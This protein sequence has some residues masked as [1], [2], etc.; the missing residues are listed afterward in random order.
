MR[1]CS[2]RVNSVCR[3]R[4]LSR[5]L[6]LVDLWVGL[7]LVPQKFMWLLLGF[8]LGKRLLNGSFG[9]LVFQGKKWPLQ[10]VVTLVDY[11]SHGDPPIGGV[12][13]KASLVGWLRKLVLKM[14]EVH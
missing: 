5:H 6:R 2:V 4:W 1:V 7:Q 13:L 14:V 10:K 12:E 9:N 8:V 11:V 3:H